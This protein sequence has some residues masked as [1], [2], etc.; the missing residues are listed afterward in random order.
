LASNRPTSI[1]PAET[2]IAEIIEYTECRRAVIRIVSPQ[3]AVAVRTF[4]QI[5]P[6]IDG[7]VLTHGQEYDAP[8]RRS[9]SPHAIQQ[10]LADANDQLN[11]IRRALET[12]TAERIRDLT[13][14]G[15][16]DG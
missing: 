2:T 9:P 10:W 1:A 12:R 3:P 8:A 15:A 11:R 14:K 7:C 6:G 4:W 16:P 5:E 13:A